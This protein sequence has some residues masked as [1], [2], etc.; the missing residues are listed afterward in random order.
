MESVRVVLAA[1]LGGTKT[2]VGVV[3]REGAILAKRKAAAEKPGPAAT[4]AQVAELAEAAL[5][6]ASV[7]REAVAGAGVCVPGIY[8]EDSGEAWA[9][10]LWGGGQAP[11]KRLLEPR[12]PAPV[13]IDSDRSACVLAEQWLGAARGLSD[14]V[15]LAVGTGIGAGIIAGGRLVRGASGI[16]GAVGW[17]ALAPQRQPLYRQMGCFEAEAA[18]P[19]VAR[20]AAALG[21]PGLSPEKVARRARLG[22]PAAV[23]AFEQT[24]AWLGMGVANIVSLLNPQMVVLGGGLMQAGDLLLEGVRRHMLAWAQPVSG[25]EVRLE[26]SRLGEDA[27][28]LGAARLAWLK[29]E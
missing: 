22:D 9:P 18:G 27:G 23:E 6:D 13:V 16:A 12:L 24:A 26:L 7:S 10:N 29:G 1:D 2:A 11:I 4:A 14:V 19:A 15:F 28:L 20:R 8:F 25:E 21:L 17:F 5:A 3:N